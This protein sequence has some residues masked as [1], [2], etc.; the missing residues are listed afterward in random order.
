[1]KRV[2][3]AVRKSALDVM[4]PESQQMAADVITVVERGLMI[5]PAV[6]APE[7]SRL[8]WMTNGPLWAGNRK[9]IY[10]AVRKLLCNDGL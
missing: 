10:Y 7:A 3:Q 1:M 2:T 5:V 4:V 8:T 6:V 9:E